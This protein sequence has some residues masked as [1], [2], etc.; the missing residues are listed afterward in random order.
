MP[1]ESILQS[2]VPLRHTGSTLLD[3][4]ALRFRYKS[5]ED[6]EERIASGVV[7]VNGVSVPPGKVLA[8]G[9]RVAYRV[10]LDEPVVDTNIRILHEERSFLVAHKPGQLPSHADGRFIKNTFVYLLA[11]MLKSRG[12][13]GDIRLVHRLDRETSGLMVVSRTGVAHASLMRQFAA[14]SVEKEY[15][16]VAKGRIDRELFEV[17]GWVGRDPASTVSIRQGLV[18]AET[19]GA[20]HSLTKF[21]VVRLM[22]DSTLLKCVP[23]TGRTNQIRVHLASIGHPVV[24]DKLYGKTDEEFLAFVGHVKAGG[25]ASFAGHA[26]TPRHLLHASGLGFNHPETGQRVD[27]T[28]AMPDDMK[29]Y[30]DKHQKL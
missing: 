30:V 21:S 3:Y 4:L 29:E 1:D 15:L 22:A 7:T 27:F 11:R 26:E 23:R 19:R 8:H 10:V 5:R 16:A 20:K 25:E 14:G 24:G 9:D 6:W 18:P 2:K 17:A 13:D 12:L 28:S